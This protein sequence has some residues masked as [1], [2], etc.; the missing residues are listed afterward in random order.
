MPRHKPGGMPV[1]FAMVQ[2]CLELA[3]TKAKEATNCLA[4]TLPPTHYLL[5]TH[6]PLPGRGLSSNR[7]ETYSHNCQ[8]GEALLGARSQNYVWVPVP[9]IKFGR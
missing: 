1:E 2:H 8:S 9:G 5:P 6:H 7:V 3:V 4:S